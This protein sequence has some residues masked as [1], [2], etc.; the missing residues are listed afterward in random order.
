MPVPLKLSFWRK[1][2]LA[3][4]QISHVPFSPKLSWS[5]SQALDLDTTC[6]S[7]SRHLGNSGKTRHWK[8]LGDSGHPGISWHFQDFLEF[9]D[10]GEKW[11][12]T[13]GVQKEASW[14]SCL[15]EIHLLDIKIHI[16]G[17]KKSKIVPNRPKMTKNILHRFPSLSQHY[18]SNSRSAT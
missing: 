18:I 13:F 4:G 2:R 5:T 15:T 3:K 1:S 7:E 14:S 12:F 17:S 10:Y 9:Q 11:K 8:N 16:L 6:R